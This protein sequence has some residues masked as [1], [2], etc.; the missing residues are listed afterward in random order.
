[1]AGDVL[2]G[3]TA[4]HILLVMRSSTQLSL[5]FKSSA[6]YWTYYQRGLVKKTKAHVIIRL[7]RFFFASA[8][9]SSAGATV[10]GVGGQDPL[11]GQV[12]QPCPLPS[13]PLPAPI[14]ADEA[15]DADIGRS[16]CEQAWPEG[17][18]FT[19]TALMRALLS[20][21]AITSS[22]CRMRAE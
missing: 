17:S 22:S 15:P 3:T 6:F 4:S 13:L 21:A 19:L 14:I 20:S 5:I 2:A 18:T 1:M 7:F 16:L 10:V 11:L 8:F 9:C 12:Y